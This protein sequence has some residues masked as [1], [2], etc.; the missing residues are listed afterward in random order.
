MSLFVLERIPV[1]ISGLKNLRV[2]KTTQSSFENFVTDEY[3]SLPDAADRVF[4]YI[5][6]FVKK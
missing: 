2:L 1:V 4:R 5:F 6:I 3:R